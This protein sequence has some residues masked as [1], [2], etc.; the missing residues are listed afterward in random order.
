MYPLFLTDVLKFL[1]G[2]GTA[3]IANC[4]AIIATAN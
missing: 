2:E 4:V 3:V 1:I